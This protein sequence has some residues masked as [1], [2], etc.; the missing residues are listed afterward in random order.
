[1]WLIDDVVIPG[2]MEVEAKLLSGVHILRC[3]FAHCTS[4]WPRLASEA[5][6]PPPLLKVLLRGSQSVSTPQAAMALVAARQ[7]AA[8]APNIG[9]LDRI[10]LAAAGE[11]AVISFP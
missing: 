9:P 3:A 2:Y 7:P 8:L 1:M 10:P 6:R 11:L 4:P 5:E